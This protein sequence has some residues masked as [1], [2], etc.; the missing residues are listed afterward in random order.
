MDAEFR[1][2][3]DQREYKKVYNAF[4]SETLTTAD[5]FKSKRLHKSPLVYK[6]ET[7]MRDE[8]VTGHDW[9]VL[10]VRA[11]SLSSFELFFHQRSGIIAFSLL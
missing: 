10:L 1:L 9:P 6:A 4:L 3:N 5:D 7:M 8:L 2:S 11:S